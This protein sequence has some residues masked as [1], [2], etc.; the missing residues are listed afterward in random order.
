MCFFDI[1]DLFIFLEE[2][3]ALATEAESNVDHTGALVGEDAVSVVLRTYSTP[4]TL[5][6][7]PD[8]YSFDVE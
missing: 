3:G 4:T 6:D 5:G 1:G 7:V 2:P 8:G